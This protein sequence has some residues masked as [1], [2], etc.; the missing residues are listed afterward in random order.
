MVPIRTD[1][2]WIADQAMNILYPTRI[3]KKENVVYRY[4]PLTDELPK[5]NE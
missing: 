1:P 3:L 5:R 2:P 4:A